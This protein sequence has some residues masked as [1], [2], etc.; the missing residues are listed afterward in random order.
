MAEVRMKPRLS[1]VLAAGGVGTAVTAALGSLGVATYF[2]RRVVTPEHEKKDDTWIVSVDRADDGPDTITLVASPH[3]L[4]SGRYGLWLDHGEGHARVG[5]VISSDLTPRKSVD[6]TVV[7]ELL[8][9][10]E[11]RLVP[12]PARWNSYYYSGDPGTAVGL[13]FENV[14]V[15]SDVGDLP[16]W[17]VPPREDTERPGEWAVL[18][19]GRS[20]KREETI[21][22][23]PLLHDLGFTSL[24]PKYRNDQGAPPSA[25]GRYNL[26]LSEWRDVEAAISYAVSQGA[27]QVTLLGW[28]MGG[29]IVLQTLDRSDY[30]R[31]V[32]KVVLDCPVIDWGVVLSHHADLNKLPR[33]ASMLGKVLMGRKATRHLVG[34]AEPLDIAVTNW[35]ARA[36]E[37]RHRILLMHSRTDDVVPY[38]PS[39]E[40]ANKRADLITLDLWDGPLHCR[41][42]NT[43][44]ERW[45]RTLAAFLT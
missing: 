28:S 7:R 33:L 31:F 23:L 34:V 16:A 5:E 2:A 6:R 37:L 12:G 35:V 4:S 39:E 3:T 24:V 44:A 18:V 42:W 27:R 40:L 8:D 15:P 25:D 17:R 9:L 1:T 11:G 22:A 14:H 21:R 29:A 41:E 13:D 26:G 19:H 36:G 10:D 45:E 43:D 32:V 30:A 38:G 20:A